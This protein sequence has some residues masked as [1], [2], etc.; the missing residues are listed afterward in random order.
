[1][2]G[3]IGTL[4]AQ[5]DGF[6]R[7]VDS[8]AEGIG[9][10]RLVPARLLQNPLLE[11]HTSAESVNRETTELVE[12]LLVNTTNRNLFRI[13]ELCAFVDVVRRASGLPDS[14]LAIA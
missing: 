9:S 1:M 14:L 12:K 7:L 10:E 6:L 13:T 8:A 4:G 11:L 5:L 2:V 3:A